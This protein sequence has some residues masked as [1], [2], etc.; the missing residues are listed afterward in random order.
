MSRWLVKYEY[1]TYSGEETV[2]AEDS[3][4]AISKCW[5]RLRRRGHLGLPMAYTSAKAE[6][7]GDGA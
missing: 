2:E 4:E 3:D 1:A 6:P 5:A 7:I